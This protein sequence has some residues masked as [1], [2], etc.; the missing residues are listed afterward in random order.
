LVA[1]LTLPDIYIYF[2]FIVK[3]TKRRLW[4][5]LYWVPALILLAGF[6]LLMLGDNALARHPLA[7]GRYAVLVFLLLIPKVLFLLCSLI[8][9]PFVYGLHCRR[10]PFTIVGLLLAAVSF[11]CVLYGATAGITRFDVKEVTYSHP[12]LPKGFDGYRIVQLSDIHTGSWVG[13]QKAIAELVERVNALQPDLILFTGDLV[14]QRAVELEGFQSILAGL[15]ARDGVYSVLGNHDYGRYYHWKSPADEAANLDSLRAKER[16]M[17]WTL[18]DNDHRILRHH[19]DSIRLAG[20]GNYDDR[21]LAVH[22][23]PHSDLHKALA[24][25]DSDSLFTILMSHNP[26]HWRSQVLPES[27]VRLTLAGHTH[28]MQVILFGHSLASLLYPEWRGMY[29]EG[30]RSLYVNIGIGFVGLPL[31]FGAWPEITLFTLRQ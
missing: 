4:R 5:L 11:G 15:H 7:I 28:G 19:G 21:H 16:E 30:D 31:R 24:G 12:R 1:F 6:L 3:K 27:H 29:T 26:L 17:G 13:N 2:V 10:A 22:S 9:L 23:A 14:N 25:V 18:L 8:G 20:V